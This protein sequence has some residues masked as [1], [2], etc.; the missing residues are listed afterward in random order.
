MKMLPTDSDKEKHGKLLSALVDKLYVDHM[1]ENSSDVQNKLNDL[2]G[3]LGKQEISVPKQVKLIKKLVDAE[4][5]V[6]EQ[7]KV[8]KAVEQSIA[9]LKAR[10]SGTAKIIVDR[11]LGKI[12]TIR[13]EYESK[14]S[15]TTKE[16]TASTKEANRQAKELSGAKPFS[17]GKISVDKLAN[18]SK[19]TLDKKY[20][21]VIA[22]MKDKLANKEIQLDNLYADLA[23]SQDELGKIREDY[24]KLK[25]NNTIGKALVDKFSTKEGEQK[26]PG[27]EK[28]VNTVLKGNTKEIFKAKLGC[29]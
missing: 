11:L 26:F 5:Y 29:E 28:F 19:A 27:V 21:K 7:H 18:G 2:V 14:Y 4:I 20:N 22:P 9:R 13:K 10:I 25:S 23:T 12:D 15:G 8:I 24:K 16:K 3:T 6:K 17:G 1:K